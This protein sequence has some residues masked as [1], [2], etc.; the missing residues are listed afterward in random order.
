MN[1]KETLKRIDVSVQRAHGNHG[2]LK[3]RVKELE[4]KVFRLLVR[5]EAGERP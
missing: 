2:K 4:K 5:I 3:M 1:V